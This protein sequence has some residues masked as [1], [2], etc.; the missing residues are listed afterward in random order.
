MRLE[1]WAGL[2]KVHM[3]LIKT[4]KFYMQIFPGNV[5]QRK[6]TLVLA[7]VPGVVSIMALC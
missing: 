1:K 4:L 7:G 6:R 3:C 5:H 2:Q